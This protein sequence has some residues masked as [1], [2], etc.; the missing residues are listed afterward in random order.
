MILFKYKA[1]DKEGRKTS[2]EVEAGSASA[3]VRLLSERG[4]VVVSL[5]S[6]GGVL[7]LLQKLRS[8]VSLGELAAFTRQLSTM[9][10]AG[11]TISESLAILRDQVGKSLSRVVERILSDIEGG[12]SLAQAL[13]RHPKVFSPVYVALVR[14]G[15]TGGIL[16][17]VLA[18]L[19]EN[20]EKQREF[21]GKLVGALVYPVIVIIGMIVVVF[22]MLIFVV[23]KL[24][25]IYSE[26]N[27]QLPLPTRVL[28]ATSSF[29]TKFWWFV[30]AVFFGLFWAFGVFRRSKLGRA[31]TD[32]LLLNIPI[33]GSLNQHLILAELT[34]TLGLL[35]GAGVSILESLETVAT[36]TGNE[37]FNRAIRASARDVER[38]FPLAYA[39]SQHPNVFPLVISRMIAVGEE[40]GKL[41]EVL[42]KVA[43][44]LDSESETK[45][46]SVTSALEP[47][48]MIILGVGVGIL[49]IS[50]IL[51]IYDLTSQ[52]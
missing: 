52:F 24:S 7:G 2:G 23:P 16:E 28:I 6:S 45:L 15:E 14:A 26:F 46:R 37:L 3:A 51:P 9:V 10:T 11:I 39:L 27:A 44:I 8:D 5:S 1:R 32:Q 17:E 25:Q 21:K 49:V 47:I 30:G 29:F 18:R 36:I 22:I 42:S 48:I 20:L 34:R 13:D 43:H 38:G 12:S 35:V 31:K 33:L 50:I 19:A 40:T 4:L 41:D